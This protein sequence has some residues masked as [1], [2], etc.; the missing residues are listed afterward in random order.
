MRLIITENITLDG[1]IE[2]T[3]GWFDPEGGDSDSSDLLAELQTMMRSEDGLLLGRVTF[4][5]FRGYWPKQADDRT[6]ITDHLNRVPK[7]VVSSTLGDPEWE[8]TTVLSKDPIV[9]VRAL[10]EKPGRDLGVTGSI[11]LCHAL[12]TADLVDEY[13]LFV[14]PV[15][16]GEGRRLFS[17]GVSS[18]LSLVEAKSFRSGVTLLTYRRR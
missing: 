12:I 4:E 7:Y 16:L 2:A 6:G 18:K 13:R 1:V 17:D 3:G 8:N 5:S 10:K 14:Y 15:V 11:K 9:E